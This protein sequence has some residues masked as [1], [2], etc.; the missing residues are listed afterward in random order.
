MYQI[1]IVASDK[2]SNPQDALTAKDVSPPFLIANALPNLLVGTPTIGGDKSVTVRG[3]VLTQT[4]FVKAVQA[5]VDDGDPIAAVADDGLFDSTLESYT[6]ITP[7]LSS[8]PHKIEVQA[9]D[10]AGNITTQQASV[11]IP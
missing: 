8:G 3:T 6:L 4:A 11:K 1:Q 10:Q 7:P 2:V 5:K 9:V